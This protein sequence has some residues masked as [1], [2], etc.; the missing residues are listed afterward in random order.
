MTFTTFVLCFL[1]AFAG[2]AMNDFYRWLRRR[3]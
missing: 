3:P 1:S 2:A